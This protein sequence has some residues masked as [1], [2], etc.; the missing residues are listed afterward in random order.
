MRISKYLAMMIFILSSSTVFADFDK[1]TEKSYEASRTDKAVVI[2]GVNWSRQWGCAG[3]DNAQLHSLT[4][5]R[6]DFSSGNLSG[7]DVVLNN[8]AKLL[9]RN[10][11]ESYAIIVETGEYALT[12]FD[13]K[14]AKSKS[15]VSHIKAKNKDLFENGRPVG[16]TFKVNAGEIVY[17]GDF[18]LDCI[19]NKPIPWRY[20]IQKEDFESYVTGFKE[21]YKFIGDKQIIYRLF[22]TDKFGQ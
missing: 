9:A 7:E 1:L 18:G 14:V 2:F 21:R 10:V 16:G 17:I 19:G 12:G 3:L 4:F 8:P 22:Q 5:S 15:D 13:I 20:Y 6:I 11:S